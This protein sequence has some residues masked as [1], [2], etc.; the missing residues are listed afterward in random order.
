MRDFGPQCSRRI[1]FSLYNKIHL[2]GIQNEKTYSCFDKGC[3]KRAQKRTQQCRK[4]F[5]EI[6]NKFQLKLGIHIVSTAQRRLETAG[7]MDS[8]LLLKFIGYFPDYLS[9]DMEVLKAMILNSAQKLK[10]NLLLQ[11]DFTRPEK[12]L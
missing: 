5:W 4:L 1:F 11:T 8:E 2:C 9:E 7:N 6:P 12:T 3:P 10:P